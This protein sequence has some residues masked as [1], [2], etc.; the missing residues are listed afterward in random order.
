MTGPGTTKERRFTGRQ[1]TVM[2]VAVCVAVAAPA[3]AYAATASFVSNSASTPAVSAKNTASGQGAKAVLGNASARHGTTYG[4]YGRATSG[5]G[6]GVYA[7]GRLGT[8]GKLACSH[9]VTGGDV[10]VAGFPTVPDAKSLGG[11][12]PSYYARTVPLSWVG[13]VAPGDQRL[14]DVDGLSVYVYCEDLGSKNEVGMTVATDTSAS[15]G[16]LNRFSVYAAGG[17][18]ATATG[19]PLSTTKE[20]IDASD[21]AI[22][23]EGTAI[24]R[25]NATGRIITIDFHLYGATCE[26]FGDVVTAG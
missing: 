18:S 25:N 22:Q 26:A 21:G 20:L 7:A 5:N 13:S 23:T 17:G 11:H 9:C 1:I 8:S 2:V 6:Y 4:V 15:A 10:D 24:F 19:Y 16:T 12:A 14:A 3:A